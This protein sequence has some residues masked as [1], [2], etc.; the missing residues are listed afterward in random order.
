[1]QRVEAKNVFVTRIKNNTVYVTSEE[2][3]LPDKTDQD[4][5][6]ENIITL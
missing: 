4:I 1:M 3:D 6:K 2:L 5:L